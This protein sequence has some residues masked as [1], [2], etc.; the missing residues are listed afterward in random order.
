MLYDRYGRPITSLRVTVTH[1]CNYR[2]FYCHMEGELGHEE[3]RAEEIFRL[4]RVGKELGIDKVKLTGGEPLVRN[5]VIE[6]I[7]LIASLNLSDLAMTTNGS[8]LKGIASKL[9]EAGLRRVN[10]SLPS[11]KEGVFEKITG[12]RMLNNVIEGLLE[13]KDCNLDPI[14]LNVVLLKGLNDSEVLDLMDFARKH[15]FILQLIELEPVGIE[16]E[17]YKAHHVPLD[18]IE[19]WLKERAV[20]VEVRSYMHGRRQYD[21][22]SLKVEVVKPVN[23][24][25]FCMHCTRL[26]ITADGKLKPCLMRGDNLIDVL[27]AIRGG[28]GDEEL[29]KLFIKAVEAKEPYF[30]DGEANRSKRV[31]GLR[32]C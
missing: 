9:S 19:E 17:L 25:Y 14:K 26:R 8:L 27:G 16:D 18:D 7:R 10:V 21:L 29:A 13:A 23:N 12:V 15:E 6:I 28:D 5:D 4:V 32:I 2:C 30:K 22:G 11:L 31:K 24:P 20:K 1:R 3:L